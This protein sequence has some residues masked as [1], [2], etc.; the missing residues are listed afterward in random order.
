MNKDKM[1]DYLKDKNKDYPREEEDKYQLIFKRI[2]MKL[3][4]IKII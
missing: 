1:K 3:F 4:M 2:E